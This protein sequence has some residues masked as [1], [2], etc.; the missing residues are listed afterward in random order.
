MK[1]TSMDCF[2]ITIKNTYIKGN[3]YVG[4]IGVF[5]ESVDEQVFDDMFFT[6]FWPML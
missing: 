1:G 5:F 3:L 4:Q 6:M 2:Y